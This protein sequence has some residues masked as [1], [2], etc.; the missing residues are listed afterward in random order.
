MKRLIVNADALGW[1]EPVTRGILQAH[2]E[3]VLTSTTVMANLPGAAEALRLARAEAPDL[4]IGIHLNLTEG[5]PLAPV[6]EVAPLVDAEGN[7]RR[8]LPA[9]WRAARRS[10]AVRQAIGRELELQVAWAR[11]QGLAPSHF[12]SHKHVHLHPAILPLVIALAQR[13][14]VRAIR[15]TAEI[16]LPH[17]YH[18]LPDEWTVKDHLRQWVAGHVARRWGAAAR[19]AVGRAGLR[20]TDWFFGVRATG[21]VSAWLLAYLMERAPDGTG[22]LMVH[23]GLKDAESHRPTRLGESRPKELAAVCDPKVRAAAQA[24]GW[25]WA[26]YGDLNHD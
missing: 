10:E 26:T 19:V 17:L 4:A 21:G 6:G 13:H 9:L 22:E 5:R 1:S 2:R 25:T 8:S 18:F 16:R 7:L 12:D 23:P 14:G 11:D 15:T 24:H 20:T 3:G